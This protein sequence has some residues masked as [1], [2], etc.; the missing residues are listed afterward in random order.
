M[1]IWDLSCDIAVESMLG[2]AG[3][4][5]CL[6]AEKGVCPA[7]RISNELRDEQL[8]LTYEAVYRYLS[9]H[10]EFVR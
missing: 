5:R 6:E 10:A 9:P 4:P 7:G 2:F 8:V 3:L 1:P